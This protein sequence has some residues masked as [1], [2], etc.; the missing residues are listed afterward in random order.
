MVSLHGERL[1]YGIISGGTICHDICSLIMKFVW[2]KIY[3][4]GEALP[5]GIVSPLGKFCHGIS[6]VGRFAI[7]YY[8]TLGKFCHGISYGIPSWGTFAV[9][10][11]FRGDNLPWYLFPHHEICVG[12]DLH[13]GGS[14]TIWYY[15]PSG[16][17]LPWDFFQGKVCHMVFLQ[18]ERLPYGI[19]SGCVCGGGGRG[20]EFPCDTGVIGSDI[21]WLDFSAYNALTWVIT[22]ME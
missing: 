5:Y 14:I 3:I 18:G 12:E 15:F 2:G 16:E 21:P 4:K 10:Y 8:S 6:S 19:I 1:P 17:V 9:W 20:G 7:L 11:H 13:K 22:L